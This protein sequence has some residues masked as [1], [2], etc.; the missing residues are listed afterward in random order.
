MTR[1]AVL[2]TLGH[3]AS[4]IYFDGERAYGFEEERL[5]R[6]KSESRYPINSIRRL[7]SICNIARGSRVFVSHWF[8]TLGPE[9][10]PNGK[11]FDRALFEEFV[12]KY[13][14]V[15][16]FVS[17]Q[18]TK[19]DG[20]K[21]SF[22]HHD[23]HCWSAMA[24]F[25]DTLTLEHR[26]RLGSDDVYS[27]VLDGFGNFQEVLSVY[28]VSNGSSRGSRPELVRRVHGYES[29][30]GLMYQYATSYCGMKEN[31]D[32]YKFLGY[33]SHVHEVIS[34]EQLTALV[35]ACASFPSVFDV[36]FSEGGNTPRELDPTPGLGIN[37]ACLVRT[38]ETWYTHFDKV[39][40]DIGCDPDLM[41]PFAKRAVVGFYVQSAVEGVMSS[42]VRQFDMKHVVTS[43][44]VFY[45]VKLN[46][47][48]LK[49]V[50]GLFS[51]IP[52]AGDQGCAIGMYEHRIGG[53]KYG[54][55]KWSPRPD[56]SEWE[57]CVAV[58]AQG[59]S[60]RVCFENVRYFNDRSKFVE[61]TSQALIEDKIVNIIDGAMEY[62]PRALCS[63]TTLA[64][65]SKTNIETIN[66][67]NDRDTVM[68]MAPVIPFECANLYFD[69]T[70][71]DRV[72][73]SDR[74][75]IVTYDY[76]VGDVTN[77][78]GVAHAYPVVSVDGGK[79]SGRPQFV[80]DGPGDATM[81]EIFESFPG[82]VLVNTSFNAHGRPIVY[83][84]SDIIDS[85][86]FQVD[87]ALELGLQPP[88][89]HILENV[90]A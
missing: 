75:M 41:E 77:F 33:E 22:T 76:A 21:T 50:P 15:P 83:D 59:G 81:R 2:L 6:R 39:L 43:G 51:V 66:S 80:C 65:P 4:A 23:A 42:L 53:F 87:R 56:L 35:E 71:T 69:S 18:E 30:M 11:Y 70:D 31:Q 34:T 67:L 82:S 61:A 86:V 14:L 17:T 45:N 78:E 54:D 10:I 72:V 27:I 90:N 29:S 47:R 25:W 9:Q 55:L 85:Y 52:L 40:R 58:Q 68:P 13:D 88:L 37:L 89:L 49:T 36:Y 24:F 28:R 84:I 46:N 48:L 79:Y 1:T 64:R 62:G 38:K 26:A 16:E 44:G 7:E 32:E 12:D 74:F 20:S 60:M 73:G 57:D 63:T 3:N 19:A 8:D 5:T